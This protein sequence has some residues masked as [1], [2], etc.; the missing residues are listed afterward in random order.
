MSDVT[1]RGQTHRR[2]EEA[3]DE[4]YFASLSDLLVGMLFIFIIM[5]MAYALN[6]RTATEKA[7][8]NLQVAEAARS[9]AEADRNI[10]QDT[11]RHARDLKIAAEAERKNAHEAEKRAQDL[12]DAA[13]AERRE[14]RE[15][16]NA[17][18]TELENAQDQADRL[19]IEADKAIRQ[20]ELVRKQLLEQIQSELEANQIIA[21]VDFD[22]GILRLPESVLFE[23]G[24]ATFDFQNRL[25]M[26]ALALVLANKMPCYV[27]IVDPPIDKTQCPENI[28]AF[29]DTLL[30][31]GHTDSRDIY[32]EQFRD[33]W[34]L[35]SARAINPGFPR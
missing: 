28:A 11:A 33:N 29:V 17:A 13:E 27:E 4:N 32:S 22:T 5:L 21:E 26:V 18:K 30:I 31:E 25:N 2:I 34:E 7:E 12:K 3:E 19:R 14:A 20:S 23:S 16:A 8:D 24:K 35:S 10:A 9:A 15:A 6:F 1:T